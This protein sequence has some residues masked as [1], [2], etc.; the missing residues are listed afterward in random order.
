M[1][2]NSARFVRPVQGADSGTG[3][4]QSGARPALDG[5]LKPRSIAIVGASATPGSFGS[6][7]LENL[8]T[9]GYTGEIYLVNPKLEAIHGRPCLHSAAELPEGIDCA[10]LAIPHSAVIDSLTACT[11]RGVRSAIIFSAGFAEIDEA[12]KDKQQQI[13]RLAAD[14]GMV[15]EGPNCLGMVNFV[16][17]IPLTFVTVPVPILDEQE[18]VAIISQSGAMA[19]V[20]GVSLRA[21]G[22]GISYL[23]STGNEAASSVEDYLEYLIDNER[24]PVFVMIVELFR[25]PK[26]FLRL[27]MSARAHG[28]HIVLLHPGRSSAARAA[29]ATHTGALVG[30]YQVMRTCVEHAGVIF[31]ET[32]EELLDVTDILMRC[33]SMPAKGACVLTESGAFKTLALDFCDSVGLELPALGVE[34]RRSLR[35]VMP[36][37]IQPSNP[38]DITAHALVDLDLYRRTLPPLLADESIGSVVLSIILTDNSTG[39]RKALPI[40]DA[41]RAA[42]S[43]KPILFAALDEGAEIDPHFVEELHALRVPFFPSPERALRAL[44]CITRAERI[45]RVDQTCGSEPVA[46]PSRSKQGMLPEYRSKEILASIG[47]PTPKGALANTVEEAQEIAARIGFPL[48]LKIQAAGLVHKGDVGGLILNVSSTDQLFESW[49]KLLDDVKANAPDAPVDGV[50]IEQ[51]CPKGVELIAGVRNDSHWGLMLVV[52]FGGVFAEALKDVRLLPVHLDVAAIIS[53]IL[54]LKCAPLLRGC[55]HSPAVDVPAA[56]RIVRRLGDL[57]LSHPEIQE[58]DINPVVVYPEGQGAIALDALMLVQSERP[59]GLERSG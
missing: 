42:K 46:L 41:I 7:V 57:A 44:A 50:L 56:A 26:K 39:N 35:E 37:F 48:A 17:S 20:L 59:S 10:V 13:A 18:G 23:V 51:M 52:G 15:I 11:K 45:R 12:G 27:A 36:D 2:R 22:L 40:L 4:P 6:S 38:L 43:T 53:E 9:A 16:D 31:V 30:E 21:H 24:A 29:A 14:H 28:K 19:A 1:T 25:Q 34:T 47:I 54:A 33:P 58:A 49:Q 3:N 5:L 8:E 55:R 32:V